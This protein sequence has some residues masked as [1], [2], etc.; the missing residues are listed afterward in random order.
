MAGWSSRNRSTTARS[1]ASGSIA[2]AAACRARCIAASCCQPISRMSSPLRSSKA[3]RPT[4]C[5]VALSSQGDLVDGPFEERPQPAPVVGD[6]SPGAEARPLEAAL[7]RVVSA[8]L[9]PCRRDD[10][11]EERTPSGRPIEAPA[12]STAAPAGIPP[13]W[14]ARRR[15][16]GHVL[17]AR[18]DRLEALR[19]RREVTREEREDAVADL[20]HGRGALLP[21]AVHVVVEQ[22]S[23]RP[24]EGDLALERGA[25]GEA[26]PDRGPRARPGSADRRRSR[27]R[28]PRGCASPAGDRR[29]GSRGRWPT[30][31]CRSMQRPRSGP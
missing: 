25:R 11:V 24:Q 7:A 16:A 3:R 8:P 5:V 4:S 26:P 23:A 29:H 15:S 20:V 27:P 10:L 21:E 31:G 19:E 9:R 28:S 1:P 22:R 13:G 18:G 14:A 12:R 2:A 17:Q 30:T 6:R